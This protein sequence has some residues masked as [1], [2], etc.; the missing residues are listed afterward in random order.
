M[1]LRPLLAVCL[2][3]AALCILQ[4]RGSKS[5]AIDCCEAIK[6]VRMHVKKVHLLD[7]YIIQ[8]PEMGCPIAALVL[9]TKA[10]R[11]LCYPPDSRWGL[12]LKEALDRRNTLKQRRLR[13]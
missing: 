3:A 12:A 11:G 13:A 5:S 2:L 8:K 6:D 4:V 9:I 7:S 10:G 1:A